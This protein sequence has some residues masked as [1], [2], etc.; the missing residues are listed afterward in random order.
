M[1]LLGEATILDAVVA[2]KRREVAALRPRRDRLRAGA[3]AAAAPRDFAGALRRRGEVALVAEIKTRSPSGGEIRPGADAAGVAAR[4]EAGGAAALS[5]L[6]DRRFFGG[7]LDAL[8]TVRA[9][10]RLPVLRKDF[11]LDQLQLWEAR[12]A[13]ADAVLLIVR[14]LDSHLLA[15]LVSL[16]R[17][18]GMAALVETHDEAEIER[19]HSAG[20]SLV[21]VNN[22]DLATLETDL[23]RCPELVSKLRAGVTAVAESGVSTRDYVQRLGRAGFDAVLV[24]ESLLRQP[25]ARA[26]AALLVGVKKEKR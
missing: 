2:E 13:G 8:R 24:G 23:E 21:G 7:S 15:E 22:R 17:E 14:L 12:A 5:V 11:V 19:A 18:L 4:Y 3:E 10:V 1:R 20:A 16:A 26:A 25:D 6:T 9:R